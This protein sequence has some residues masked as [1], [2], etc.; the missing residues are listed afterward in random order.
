MDAAK[1]PY[2]RLNTY[3][4]PEAMD[5]IDTAMAGMLLVHAPVSTSALV[6]A[7]VREGIERCR[8]D[9]EMLRQIV[10]KHV[11]PQARRRRR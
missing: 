2:S 4:S 11:G 9:A 7:L 1:R 8:G 6:E 10:E 3:L 5:A